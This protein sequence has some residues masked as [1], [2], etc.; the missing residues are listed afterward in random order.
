MVPQRDQRSLEPFVVSC[1]RGIKVTDG[2]KVANQLTLRCGNCC[3]L[4]WQAHCNHQDPYNV[5]EGGRRVSL[6]KM[7][8]EEGLPYHY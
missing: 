5:E 3:D 8:C 2:N 7:G 1:Q 6:R 4:S